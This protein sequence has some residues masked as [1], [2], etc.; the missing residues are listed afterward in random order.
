MMN[1]G[2]AAGVAQGGVVDASHGVRRIA[3]SGVRARRRTGSTDMRKVK[4]V[5]I[6]ELVEAVQD[7]A[8]SDEEAVAVL[9]HLL[10]SARLSRPLPAAA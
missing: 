4:R 6:L 5:T 7:I 9:M 8:R 1:N 3:R 10:R 2:L